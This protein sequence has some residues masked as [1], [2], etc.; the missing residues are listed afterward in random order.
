LAAYA[1]NLP[2]YR[3]GSGVGHLLRRRNRGHA[4]TFHLNTVRYVNN[5]RGLARNAHEA[6]G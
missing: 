4:S 6:A 3:V 5:A 2:K 1:R